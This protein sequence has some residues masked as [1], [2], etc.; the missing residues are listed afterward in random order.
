MLDAAMNNI[1]SSMPP[2]RLSVVCLCAAWCGVCRDFL[3]AFEALAKNHPNA[4]FHRL[5]VEDEAD[6]LDDLD[7]E[8][9][10]T[11]LLGVE[12]QPVFFGTVLPQTAM[13]ERLL[14]Q[15]PD[16]PALRAHEHHATLEAVLAHCQAAG[17]I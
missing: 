12:G 11:L 4:S 7:V 16:M 17:G 3:P 9:F 15:A 13:V 8:N 10:P 14:Q 2:R 5:D 1:T 6:L